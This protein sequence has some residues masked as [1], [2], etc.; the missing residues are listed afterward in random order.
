M[1]KI[2][3]ILAFCFFGSASADAQVI[4]IIKYI[5]SKIIRAIDL[6]VQQLQNEAINLQILQKQLENNF[7]A[8]N[9]SQIASWEQKQKDLYAGYFDE[10]TKVKNAIAFTSRISEIMQKQKQVVTDTRKT[11]Q[12]IYVDNHFTV[13]EI[14][15]FVS[16]CESILTQSANNLSLMLET[17]SAGKF[18]MSDGERL[19]RL[20]QVTDD[21]EEQETKLNGWLQKIRDLSISREHNAVEIQNI[22][23][24]Y[25]FR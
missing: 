22:K 18:M 20:M 12:S 3:L 24:L 7:S 19:T 17:V 13:A 15:Q 2:I 21:E 16:G 14:Q 25:D 5:T 6:K 23:R 4:F 1:K 10:L 8:S 11:M 9:L